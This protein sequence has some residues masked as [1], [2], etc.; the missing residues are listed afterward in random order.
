[1]WGARGRHGALS[2]RRGHDRRQG[3]HWRRRPRSSCRLPR[4]V[5]AR[6]EPRPGDDPL[7]PPPS[8]CTSPQRAQGVARRPS[9]NSIASAHLLWPKHILILQLLSFDGVECPHLGQPHLPP[10]KKPHAHR[11]KSVGKGPAQ[12]GHASDAEDVAIDEDAAAAEEC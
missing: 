10:R 11:S 3:S 7:P 12:A 9:E 6:V 2:R 8:A 5:I 1:M 4:P